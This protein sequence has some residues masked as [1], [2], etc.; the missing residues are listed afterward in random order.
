MIK[1]SLI[2]IF[3][4][5]V[6]SVSRGQDPAFDMTFNDSGKVYTEFQKYDQAEAIAV[7]GDG[8]ILIGG[9]SERDSLVHFTL[10]RYDDVGKLDFL[11]GDSGKVFI[12]V[13]SG[14]EII[15]DIIPLTNGK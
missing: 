2:V 7:Q 5:L 1:L 3:I 14:Y 6:N 12:N 9:A 13:D 8:K 15:K 10:L 11:F 4:T